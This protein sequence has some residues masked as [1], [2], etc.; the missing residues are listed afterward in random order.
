MGFLVY[1][2]DLVHLKR[3]YPIYS[4]I[5]KYGPNSFKLIILDILRKTGKVSRNL[6]LERKNY[7]LFL[8]FPEYNILEKGSSSLNYKHTFETKT[9]IRAFALNSNKSSIIYSKVFIE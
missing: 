7:Y 5:N 8:L 2:Y 9:K 1:I 6:R 3:S 4:A